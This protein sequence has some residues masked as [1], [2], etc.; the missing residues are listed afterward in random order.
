MCA[1]AVEE[2][3]DA[4]LAQRLADVAVRRWRSFERRT[5]PNKRTPQAR[6]QDL[7]QGLRQASPVDEIYLE[8]GDFER[9]APRFA[10]LLA[11]LP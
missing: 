2:G 8:P 1:A 11:E 3:W 7:I 6:L 10:G 4:A 9:L 5:R